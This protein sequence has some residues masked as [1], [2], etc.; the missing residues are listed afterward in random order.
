MIFK[1]LTFLGGVRL[2]EVGSEDDIRE[3][4]HEGHNL[5]ISRGDIKF[6]ASL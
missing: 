5:L 3:S 6:V 2:N 1:L 4:R